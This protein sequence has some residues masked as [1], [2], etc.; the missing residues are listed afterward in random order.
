MEPSTL[1]TRLVVKYL[2]LRSQTLLGKRSW[3]PFLD[4]DASVELREEL[5]EVSKRFVG[6][7]HGANEALLSVS[8]FCMRSLLDAFPCPR[9]RRR[10]VALARR[11]SMPHGT[12]RLYNSVSVV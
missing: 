9:L 11:S 8:Y 3:Q 1:G 12:S 2:V 10:D 4:M 7:I 6:E 5:V